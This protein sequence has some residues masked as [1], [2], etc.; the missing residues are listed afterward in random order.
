MR[1]RS[2]RPPLR[3]RRPGSRA[4]ARRSRPRGEG[5]GR[6]ARRSTGG[7]AAARRLRR[8]PAARTR[9]PR[10]RRLVHAR[11]RP[12]PARD[13]RGRHADDRRRAARVRVRLRVAAP[14]RRLR[15]PCRPHA[16]STTTQSPSDASSTASG[17]TVGRAS[18]AAGS[19]ARS[20]TYLHGPLL[21]Q[22]PVARRLAARAGTRARVRRRA[23]GRSSRFADELEAEAF[24]VSAEPARRR[25]GRG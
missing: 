14:A 12:L 2:A 24:R 16:C 10:S 13:G 5:R 18:R 3:R 1:G 22:E 11:R 17:T 15:E 9:L 20:G 4:G 25:G 8:L 7:V 23:A 19:S 21:P 6:S